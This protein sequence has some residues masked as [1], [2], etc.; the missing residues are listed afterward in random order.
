[1]HTFEDLAARCVGQGW[2]LRQSADGYELLG[3]GAPAAWRRLEA[4]S[5]WVTRWARPGAQVDALNEDGSEDG[6]IE[7]LELAL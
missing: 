7:Q 5:E 6:V 4:C 2:E 3:N 1:M